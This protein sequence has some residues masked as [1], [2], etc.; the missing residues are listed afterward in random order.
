MEEQKANLIE[1]IK[2]GRLPISP[3]NVNLLAQRHEVHVKDII[4][5]R[6]KDADLTIVGFRSEALKQLGNK[7]FQGYDAVGN[8][9]FV[10]AVKKKEIS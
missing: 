8:V 3:N 4:N 7:L 6:S 10:N 2:A 9:L 5:E 1:L